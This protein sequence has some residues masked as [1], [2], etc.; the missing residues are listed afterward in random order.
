MRGADHFVKGISGVRETES[1]GHW[2]ADSRQLTADRNC[3]FPVPNSKICV[4]SSEFL[5]QF[6]IFRGSEFPKGVS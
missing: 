3:Q 4:V 6:L 1:R 5:I 2:S